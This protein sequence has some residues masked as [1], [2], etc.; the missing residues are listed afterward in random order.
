MPKGIC[1]KCGQEFF[2]WVLQE[3]GI[4]VCDLCGGEIV[5]MEE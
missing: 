1:Q 3:D 4:L 2:G 5:L